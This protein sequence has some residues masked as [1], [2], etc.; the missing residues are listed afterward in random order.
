MKGTEQREISIVIEHTCTRIR[1]VIATSRRSARYRMTACS[2]MPMKRTLR[3]GSY[4][5]E[6]LAG[7]VNHT[8]MSSR[9]KAHREDRRGA[10]LQIGI[11]L[12]G[13]IGTPRHACAGRP[14]TSRF[15]DDA[16]TVAFR[17]TQHRLRWS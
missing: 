11:L 3:P 13:R 14:S 10:R 15:R 5:R 12:H 4:H 8:L 9:T 17:S 16:A 7:R 2:L 1:I 6:D